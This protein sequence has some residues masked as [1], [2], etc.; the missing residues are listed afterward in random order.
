MEERLDPK[1]KSSL[2]LAK[3]YSCG[4]EIE[5][6]AGPKKEQNFSLSTKQIYTRRTMSPI[7]T[8]NFAKNMVFNLAGKN[9]SYTARK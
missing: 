8:N 2:K 1:E 6:P 9:L 7:K 5:Q 4:M 3:K